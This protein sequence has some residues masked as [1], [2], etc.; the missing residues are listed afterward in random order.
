MDQNAYTCSSAEF[1][2]NSRIPVRVMADEAAMMEDIAQ[3]MFEAILARPNQGRTVLI[4]PV[5]PVAQYPLLA[6]KINRAGCRLDHVWFINMDE[7]L[8]GDGQYLQS[9]LLSFH[10]AMR[11]FFFDRLLPS[12]RPPAEHCVFPDPNDPGAVDELLRRLGGADLSCT[13]VGINGHIAFNEPPEENDP[14]TDEAFARLPTRIL[15]ISEATRINNGGRKINGALDMFPR[16]CITL[17]MAQLLQCRR[18]KIY[19]YCDWQW[20]VMRKLALQ[21]PGRQCP[22]SFLQLH[23]NAEMV[24]SKALADLTLCF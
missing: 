13:G 10:H 14:I 9:P 3:T 1:L 2:A 7:Y 18:L 5:G 17:G 16:R 23:P 12:L 20:G 15:P 21:P 19:L 4:C 6:E 24:V 22:A 11:V 8:G